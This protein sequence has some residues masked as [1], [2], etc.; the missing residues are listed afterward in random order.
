MFGNTAM[1]AGQR[2]GMAKVRSVLSQKPA[3]LLGRRTEVELMRARVREAAEGRSGVLLVRGVAGIGKTM[4]LSALAEAARDEADVLSAVCTA[5]GARF[6][7]AYSLFSAASASVTADAHDEPTEQQRLLQ[8]GI[9]R[10]HARP[11]VLLLDDVHHCDAETAR[12][13]GLLAR[14][15]NGGRL[16]VVLAHRCA[17][18]APAEALFVELISALDT[19][20][21]DLKPLPDAAVRELIRQKF[22]V[23]P[24]EG[25]LRTCLELCNGNP[26]TT[27]ASL[28]RIAELG[29]R[30]DEDWVERLREEATVQAVASW[31]SWLQSQPEPTLRY[32][33]AVALLGGDEA[34]ATGALFELPTAAVRNARTT[35]RLAGVLTETGTFRLEPLRKHLLAPLDSRD[36][37][38]LRARAARLLSDEGRPRREV[39]EQLAELPAVNEPWMVATLRE[40][41]REC[42][43]RP[44]A[45]AR[46]LR[47][48]LEE[49]PRD[50]GIRLE[51]AHALTDIDKDA[52][53]AV[54]ADVLADLT[55]V[56]EQAST[57]VRYGAVSVL[58][59]RTDQA[60]G[61]LVEA[62]R[63]LPVDV[64]PELRL[65]VEVVLLL[66]GQ[67]DVATVA[68]AVSWAREI[69]PPSV[70]T[71]QPAKRLVQ[72]LARSELLRGESV[73][74]TLSMTRSALTPPAAPHDCWDVVPATTLHFCGEA[75]EAV[76]VLDRVLA[77]A[78]TAGDE[79]SQVLALGF[80]AMVRLDLG[81][82]TD[83]ASDAEAA[84]SHPMCE[85]W[86]LGTRLPHTTLAAVCARMG[87][88]E[89][90]LRLL[91]TESREPAV[92]G[93]AMTTQARILRNSGQSTLALDVLLRCGEEFD[94]MGIDNP[95]LVPWWL[96]AV[97]V[98][99]ELGRTDQAAGLAERGAAA[100]AR[101]DTAVARGYAA[102]ARGM[103]T[104]VPAT[105][106]DAA[107]RLSAAGYRLRGAQALTALGITLLRDGDDRSARK[108]LR[109]AVD[110]AVR[111]GDAEAVNAAR[112]ALLRAGGR[113]SRL[114][115]RD[116]LTA[117]ER[118]V[119]RLAAQGMSNR[120]IA[121]S[122]FVTVRTV[123]SHLSSAYRK[124]GAHTRADLAA[125]LQ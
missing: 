5:G 33:T 89:R 110:L 82:L 98:A 6:A 16:F 103:V 77:S 76:A 55:D 36:L 71:T 85:Q 51:L 100:A 65:A 84:L 12:W 38:A 97:T 107:H 27:L 78:R 2:S 114:P 81:E 8:L 49:T 42:P 34:D 32:A 79:F 20:T 75:M 24:H 121:E 19:T 69:V 92:R 13:L 11:L 62:W 118:R 116:V 17:E 73:R 117:G 18:R 64:D 37:A 72:Q 28:T 14:R 48:V 35:L 124:L 15:A 29:G 123:E 53:S 3:R 109:A 99:L 122:L 43:G 45:S 30:P 39:A 119:V 94:E 101:W 60:F 67:Y 56:E 106:E 68:A 63:A 21:I 115:T 74:S 41:A 23:A 91:T 25:F 26:R 95:M 46:Y 125:Q 90:A 87:D 1:R 70:P 7:A 83:A 88:D 50:V 96:D 105:L 112:A 102:L 108:Q 66:A 58:M 40:A 113:M 59:E 80:R 31:S 47:R 120:Q 104:G 22:G 4:L 86:T 52:A 61:A 10:T 111:C 44:A 57:A 54:F 93:V 9:E